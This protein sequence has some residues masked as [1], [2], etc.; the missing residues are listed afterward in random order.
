[1]CRGQRTTLKMKLDAAG[2]MRSNRERRGL[3][4]TVWRW[5]KVKREKGRSLMKVFG[6]SF[7]ST[8]WSLCS[9]VNGFDCEHEG[10][11]ANPAEHMKAESVCVSMCVCLSM[12][13]SHQI[14]KLSSNW[15]FCQV[16]QPY[17]LWLGS[18]LSHISHSQ[19]T[20]SLL[21]CSASSLSLGFLWL[22]ISGPYFGT[23]M[24][25]SG[26]RTT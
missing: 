9:A 7:V 1:M 12:L 14:D 10:E 22:A 2:E 17:E 24:N 6:P 5:R 19:H 4:T 25:Y 8:I 20:S 26:N 11:K 21:T 18:Y 15:L 16:K 3:V 23:A 13:P